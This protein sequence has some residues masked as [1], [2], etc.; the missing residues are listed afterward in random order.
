MTRSSTPDE[1]AMRRLFDEGRMHDVATEALET[2]GPEILSFLLAQLRDE[3]AAREVFSEFSERL[4]RGLSGFEW[5][6][7]LRA[8]A[9][10]LARNAAVSFKTA[11]DRKPGRNI[12]LSEA[13]ELSRIVDAVRSR[14][15]VHLRTETK[16]RIRELRER[17]SDEDQ[18][19]II[20]RVDREM[21]WRE[22]A[23]VM[24]EKESPSDLELEREA[25]RI[26][27]R[28]FEAKERLRE[29]AEKEGL[30]ER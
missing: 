20:L 19:L 16:N 22:V 24:C 9:Y 1:S 28:F 7:P 14:T 15:A 4:W 6:C 25:T 12:P 30:I 13:K 26:R 23:I 2:Y 8:W 21:S 29:M 10:T 18:A 3:S 17:L 5:K 11:A 27:R